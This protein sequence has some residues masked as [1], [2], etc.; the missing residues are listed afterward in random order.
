VV[1][2]VHAW[3]HAL[4]PTA[5]TLVL[6]AAFLAQATP[7][8]A[9]APPP[10]APRVHLE[11][12]LYDVPFN[13][14]GG[15]S[16]PSMGQSLAVGKD[17]FALAHFG[18]D[19]FEPGETNLLEALGIIAFDTLMSWIPFGDSWVHE[20][21]HRA[22]MTR[23]HVGSFDDLYRFPLFSD[24]ISV[25]HETDADLARMKL[26]HPADFVR[27]PEAGIEGEYELLLAMEKD[28][29]FHD[30]AGWN[31]GLYWLTKVNSILYVYTSGTT[32]ADK[33]TDD[34]NAREGANVAVRDFTGLDF[35][36]WVYDLHRP[37]EPYAARG[38]HPSGVGVNRYIRYSDL[39][40]REQSYLRLQGGLQ[41]LNL[42]DPNLIGFHRFAA[43][44][45][46]VEWMAS[47]YHLLTPFGFDAGLNVLLR[48]A[49]GGLS[50]RLHG[51]S[52]GA[53]T[54][55][56]GVETEGVSLRVPVG[57]ARALFVSPRLAL[58]LQ[59][60]RLRFEGTGVRPGLL[61]GARAAWPLSPAWRVYVEGDVKTEGWV[62][63][64]VYLDAAFTARAGA[65][66]FVF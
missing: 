50:V 63:G 16:A 5:A 56:P 3:C 54:L 52:S 18:L 22:V 21:W 43:R 64:D 46:A 49:H 11:L 40:P 19:Q 31:Q 20:E 28:A 15:F 1:I 58:W 30:A 44:G 60:D 2:E 14:I 48:D 13:T 36:G 38:L 10:G 35:T 42:L 24:E 32:D 62:P 37:D 25:S 39:T 65:E 59:P 45:G 7:P 23:R 27:L 26:D 55:L 53:H 66:A 4:V 8:Q 34:A 41:L 57:R 29:F 17:V 12:P 61:A 6:A 47:A 51:Y 33:L 9:A